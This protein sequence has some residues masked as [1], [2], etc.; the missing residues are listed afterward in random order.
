MQVTR[1]SHHPLKIRTPALYFGSLSLPSGS[2]VLL[3]MIASVNV[4]GGRFHPGQDR[5]AELRHCT[6]RTIIRQL[7]VLAARGYIRVIRR[8]KK[9]T[10]VYRLSRSLWGRLTGQLTPKRPNVFQLWLQQRK[11]HGNGIWATMR[12]ADL[13]PTG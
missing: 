12:E 13:R 8:G 11:L 1:M 7:K 6:R 4:S 3:E 10:N 9:L 5:L 2:A